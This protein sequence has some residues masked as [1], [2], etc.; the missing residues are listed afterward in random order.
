LETK[1]GAAMWPKIMLWLCQQELQLKKSTIFKV[2]IVM[3]HKI[4]FVQYLLLTK[5]RRW[6]KIAYD[7][8]S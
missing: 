7:V 6:N 3:T 1:M 2:F 4:I 8:T 5:F